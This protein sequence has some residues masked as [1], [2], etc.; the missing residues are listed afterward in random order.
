MNRKLKITPPMYRKFAA[1]TAS[2]SPCP[3]NKIAAMWAQK[4]TNY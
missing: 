2:A 4:I 1:I 3:Q